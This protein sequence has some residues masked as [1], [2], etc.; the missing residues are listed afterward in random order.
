MEIKKTG[1]S[2]KDARMIR[3]EVF[4]LEQGFCEEF[5]DDID[6][7]ATHLV[8]YEGEIPVAVC[9]YYQSETAGAYV[10]GR[11]AVRKPYRR[12]NIGMQV[13]EAAEREILKSGG[14]KIVLSAQVRVQG[15]YEKCGYTAQGEIYLDENCPHIRME[16]KLFEI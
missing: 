3:E 4:V 10:L 15:F 8:F 14:E 1:A 7:R 9:R 11:V 6:N 5:D 12:K 2:I 13:V 16:K